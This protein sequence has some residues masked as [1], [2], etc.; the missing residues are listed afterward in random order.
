MNKT[1]LSLMT[2][3]VFIAATGCNRGTT[4]KKSVTYQG[5]T[6]RVQVYARINGKTVQDYDQRFDVAGLD[7]AERQALATHIMDSL[8]IPEHTEE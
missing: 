5:E 3:L 4:I 1:F 6:M 7:K 2:V 8:K